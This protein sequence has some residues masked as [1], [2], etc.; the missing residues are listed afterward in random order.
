MFFCFM[1]TPKRYH[2]IYAVTLMV[3]SGA[4]NSVT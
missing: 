1:K 2:R 3:F 4:K